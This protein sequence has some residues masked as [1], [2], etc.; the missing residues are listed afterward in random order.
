MYTLKV[1]NSFF[2]GS[3]AIKIDE[4]R[5]IQIERVI[6]S[7]DILNIEVDY[8][9]DPELGLNCSGLRQFQ[10]VQVIQSG[11]QD[12]I[13]FEGY[14]YNLQP[15]FKSVKLVC[16]DYKGLLDRKKLFSAKNYASKSLDF[17]LNEIFTE[18]N[19]R[20]AGDTNPEAW[21]YTIDTN[22]TITKD[23]DK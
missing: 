21:A 17:I 15:N 19:G 18:L 1:F 7:F 9:V 16:R 20:S 14:I 2:G 5:N 23:F 8:Y 3:T 10:R 12:S 4:I 6:D 11:L 22:P 13:V